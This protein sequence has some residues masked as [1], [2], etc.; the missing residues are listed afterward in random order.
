MKYSSACACN[1]F[2]ATHHQAYWKK[3]EA[4]AKEFDAEGWFKVIPTCFLPLLSFLFLLFSFSHFHTFLQ[5]GDIVIYDSEK[6]SFRICG[7]NS[8]DII[9]RS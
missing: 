6:E 9:K 2:T 1:H 3:P 8:V 5:T 4:T 7:R